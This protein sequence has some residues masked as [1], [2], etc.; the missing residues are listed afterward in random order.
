VGSRALVTFG[1]YLAHFDQIR[2][3]LGS[4]LLGPLF[5]K[6]D[7]PRMKAIWKK[8]N[9]G[10]KNTKLFF[11]THLRDIG[12]FPSSRNVEAFFGPFLSTSYRFRVDFG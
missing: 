7:Q 8:W 3:V 10:F 9:Y 2:I 1:H 5:L 6:F 4:I 12:G 11:D